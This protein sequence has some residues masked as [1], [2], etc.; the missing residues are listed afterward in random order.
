MGIAQGPCLRQVLK[1]RRHL[2][3]DLKEKNLREMR[4]EPVRE[5]IPGRQSSM[6]KGPGGRNVPAMFGD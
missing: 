3:Q 2:S 1:R 4:R 6:C 5:S